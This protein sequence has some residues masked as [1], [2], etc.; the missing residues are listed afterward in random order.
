[1]FISR[2]RNRINL[3]KTAWD[4]KKTN[5]TKEMLNC[6]IRTEHFTVDLGLSLAFTI[7]NAT[8]KGIEGSY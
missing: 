6:Q 7:R 2:I 4:Y 3:F 5:D 1:M 8:F